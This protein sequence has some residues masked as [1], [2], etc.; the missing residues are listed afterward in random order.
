MK[1]VIQVVSSANVVI[2]G[3]I[4]SDIKKGYMVLVGI[5]KG[6][7]KEMADKLVNK[8]L[9]LRIFP[10]EN[11]KTNLNL[12][13]VNGELLLVSQF[14]L[15]ADMKRGNRPSFTEAADKDLAIELYEYIIKKCKDRGFKVQTGV[16][17][18]DMKV[19]LTNEGPF[20]VILDSRDI[21]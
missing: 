5:A 12:K 16:F 13:T 1:L 18:A 20:T 7:T 9:D 21:L 8:M 19:S 3:E 17:G 4:V 14:T 2:D 6:D 15:L 11:G 10:D